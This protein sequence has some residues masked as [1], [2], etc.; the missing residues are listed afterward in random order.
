M[1]HEPNILREDTVHTIPTVFLGFTKEEHDLVKGCLLK[2]AIYPGQN[3]IESWIAIAEA[4]K[5]DGIDFV[6]FNIN[7]G[8]QLV[9]K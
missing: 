8:L 1:I 3:P 4:F 9:H 5:A 7:Y 6:I 2:T